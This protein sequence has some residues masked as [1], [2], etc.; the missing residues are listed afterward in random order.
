MTAWRLGV[1]IAG[2]GL[3]ALVVGACESES[4]T[5]SDH[6]IVSAIPWTAPE[7]ARY[8]LMSGDEVEG[9]GVLR[10]ETDNGGFSFTQEFESG[11]FHDK[12]VAV[13]DAG[14]LRAISVDRTIDGPE[15]ERRWQVTYDGSNA[16][17]LQATED[18]ERTDEVTAPTRFYDSWTDVFVWRTIAFREGYEATYSDVL[19]ATLTTPKVISQA[20]KV[21]GLETVEVPAGTFQAWELEIRSSGGKQKAWYAD[22]ENRTLVR[23]DNGSRVFELL[24]LE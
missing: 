11:E 4:S 2:L 17:V 14:T 7:E 24:S 10:I 16:V 1:V 8:R 18:D 12:V 9:S 3:L 20:L 23:Y 13:V 5:L 6:D 15:G 19:T 21:T 22:T